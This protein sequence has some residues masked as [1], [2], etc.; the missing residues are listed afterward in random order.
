VTTF[1]LEVDLKALDFPAPE[2]DWAWLIAENGGEWHGKRLGSEAFF[3][4]CTNACWYGYIRVREGVY[5]VSRR[6][7]IDVG[8]SANVSG[9]EFR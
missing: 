6:S 8:D 7:W 9:L 1:E 5:L 3:Q 2:I 4:D